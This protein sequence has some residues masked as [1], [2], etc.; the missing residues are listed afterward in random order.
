MQSKRLAALMLALFCA[1]PFAGSARGATISPEVIDLYPRNDSINAL[2]GGQL[3][4]QTFVATGASAQSLTFDMQSANIGS[5]RADTTFDVLLTTVASNPP[6]GF[7]NQSPVRPG[8]ILFKSGTLV[9]GAD[10]SWTQFTVNL[11]GTPLSVGTSYAW[12]IDAFSPW[13]GVANSEAGAAVGAVR[14]SFTG[15]SVDDAYPDGM[16]LYSPGGTACCVT[17]LTSALANSDWL[18]LSP[19]DYRNLVFRMDFTNPPPG[20]TPLPAT[21]PLFASGLGLIGMLAWRTK[22]N[23]TRHALDLAD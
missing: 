7:G 14:N 21:L 8:S 11:G 13:N 2:D 5:G 17:D 15:T 3:Y 20:E 22:R 23:G 18:T 16:F 6:A 4:A 19:S 10:A 1:A 12:V 9:L